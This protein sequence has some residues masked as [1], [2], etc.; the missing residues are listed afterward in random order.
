MLWKNRTRFWRDLVPKKLRKLW[1]Q[2]LAFRSDRKFIFQNSARKNNL[3]NRPF[4]DHF[5]FPIRICMFTKKYT[6]NSS[7][8]GFCWKGYW[9]QHILFPGK[10]YVFYSFPILF[11]EK[12]NVRIT[13]SMIQCVVRY[14][15]S[16]YGSDCKGGTLSILCEHPSR[17]LWSINIYFLYFNLI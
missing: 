4:K 13:Y 1:K 2:S 8:R 10:L 9:R 11:S 5:R 3:S 7:A 15:W 14:S 6:K 17:S 16:H 12:I